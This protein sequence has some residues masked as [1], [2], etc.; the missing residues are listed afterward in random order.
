VFV[1]DLPIVQCPVDLLCSTNDI[2]LAPCE[3]LE[4]SRDVSTHLLEYVPE[5]SVQNAD[6]SKFV[7]SLPRGQPT[8]RQI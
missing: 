8:A 4:Q 2:L 3:L 7:P 5:K 6:P 1:L